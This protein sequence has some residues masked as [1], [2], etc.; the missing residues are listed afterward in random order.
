MIQA[1]INYHVEDGYPSGFFR[2]LRSNQHVYSAF[3]SYA[4]RMALTGRKRYSAKTITEKIRWDTDIADSE[5]TFK[6][7]NNYTSGMARLFM[8]EYG[9]RHPGFFQM[10]D[11]QGLDVE[12]SHN[13]NKAVL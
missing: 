4:F 6:V 1:T 10:R 11:S 7:N 5:V 9:H 8:Y 12:R 13:Q 3:K 2:W